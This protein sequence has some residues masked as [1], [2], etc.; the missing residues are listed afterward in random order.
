[1]KRQHLLYLS[2]GLALLIVA[3][4]VYQN[5]PA[6]TPEAL[7]PLPEIAS[8]RSAGPETRS[9]AAPSERD[10][11]TTASVVPDPA[12]DKHPSATEPVVPEKYSAAPKEP[13]KKE[14]IGLVNRLD[15]TDMAKAE[16]LLSR[17]SSLPID[18]QVL[19]MDHATKL[20]S[21]EHYVRMRPMLFGLAQ[22]SPELRETVLLDALTRSEQVRM[23]TL[24]E[25][26]RQPAHPEQAEVREILLAY[27]DVDHGTDVKAWDSAVKKF[28]ADH[29]DL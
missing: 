19:A 24:V 28:L 26:L 18:G 4:I 14:I 15:M 22:P 10:E 1:M 21:D 12:V 29:P 17:L 2:I 27:L 20:I 16:Q 5:S 11:T 25:I 9:S 8:I 3:T 6:P 23:P 7:A 13:W